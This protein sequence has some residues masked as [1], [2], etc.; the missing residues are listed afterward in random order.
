MESLQQINSAQIDSGM[1]GAGIQKGPIQHS[2]LE[3]EKVNHEDKKN[4]NEMSAY[5]VN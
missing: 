3:E 4:F 5:K 1:N 2:D